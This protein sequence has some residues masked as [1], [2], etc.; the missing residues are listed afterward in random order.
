MQVPNR[1]SAVVVLILV[2]L[3]AGC[4]SET[5]YAVAV[6]S[7][8]EVLPVTVREYEMEL[9][10]EK[11]LMAVINAGDRG[12]IEFRF[13][14]DVVD[15]GGWDLRNHSSYSS[16][17]AYVVAEGEEDPDPSMRELYLGEVG[18]VAHFFQGNVHHSKSFWMGD[19]VALDGLSLSPRFELTYESERTITVTE[20]DKTTRI[21][22]K[23]EGE[24]YGPK[25]IIEWRFESSQD[26]EET[27]ESSG[28]FVRETTGEEPAARFEFP[29]N[30]DDRWLDFTTLEEI[31]R[32]TMHNGG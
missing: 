7:E 1:C 6:E 32:P 14:D 9:D 11:F 29:E 10:G 18:V 13:G 25:T 16:G 24:N 27:H 20:G 3:L 2:A 19:Q 8:A 28:K 5:I 26:G 15:V 21:E 4:Q 30:V 31:P 22:S 17:T 23:F 12:V